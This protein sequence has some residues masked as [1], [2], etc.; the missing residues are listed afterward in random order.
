MLGKLSKNWDVSK[1][2]V[3][4]NFFNHA[5]ACVQHMTSQ[6][7]SPT[8]SPS[9]NLV[10]MPL[11]SLSRNLLAA[12]ICLGL[13]YKIEINMLFFF[14]HVGRSQWTVTVLK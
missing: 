12:V 10:V 13:L 1:V 5:I 14:L 11:V 3:H 4:C 2:R 8:P 7:Q 9:S 6:Y